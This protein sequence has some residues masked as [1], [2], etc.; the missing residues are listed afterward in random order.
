VVSRDGEIAEI[1]TDR[2]CT[3]VDL[4]EHRLQSIN[5]AGR[6]LFEEAPALQ[7][8]RAPLD[9]D[10]MYG[11]GP[12]ARWREWGLDRL[13]LFSRTSSLRRR[14]GAAIFVV[15]E[16]WHGSGT[17]IAISHRQRV[18]MDVAGIRFEH[19]IKIPRMLDDIPRVGVHWLLPRGHEDV[20]W[21][22]LGP[23]E[24]YVDRRAGVFFARHRAHVD[25]LF[26]PYVR[27]QSQ[28]NRT[29]T[30]R[31]AFRR[32]DGSGVLF[33]A[34]ESLEFSARHYSEEMLERAQHLSELSPDPRLHLYLD[35]EQRGVGTGACGPDTLPR[36]RVPGGRYRFGYSLVPLQSDDSL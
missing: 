35:A 23:H 22:G 2:A 16:V 6:A 33:V 25:D 13:S 36:Y 8:W 3:V 28:G 12:V 24:N 5:A 19:E 11:Q 27:P 20:E 31:V 17:G 4:A 10:G 30:R 26:H 14:A 7:L 34:D 15:S 21:L 1:R 9:N 32:E 29:G 18:I